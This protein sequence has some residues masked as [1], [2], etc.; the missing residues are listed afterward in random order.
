MA[1]LPPLL[2][3]K[4]MDSSRINSG[5]R[6]ELDIKPKKTVGSKEKFALAFASLYGEEDKNSVTSRTKNDGLRSPNSPADISPN[7]EKAKVSFYTGNIEP[8]PQMPGESDVICNSSSYEGFMTPIPANEIDY[9][10][11]AS[12]TE[13]P[14]DTESIDSGS[15]LVEEP[16]KEEDYIPVRHEW[17]GTSI[18]MIATSIDVQKEVH[19]LHLDLKY[20]L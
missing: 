5:K 1:T 4:K 8:I 20:P 3:E 18:Y 2:A 16:N 9:F 13:A 6:I 12:N 14:S 11:S 17:T 15:T 19:S 7:S 10:S